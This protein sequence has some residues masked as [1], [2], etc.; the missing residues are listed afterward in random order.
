MG[1]KT[2]AVQFESLD[3][4]WSG[5]AFA[6]LRAK[7]RYVDLTTEKPTTALLEKWELR[8]YPIL[9]G[10]S[11]WILFDV[12]LVQERTGD[13]PLVLDE[14]RYGGVGFR[15]TGEWLPKGALTFLSSEGKDRESGNGA[16][17]R[18]CRMSGNVDGRPAAIVLYGHPS[19]FRAPQPVRINPDQPFFCWAPP[20]LGRFEIKP[21]EP[22]V[23]RYRFAVFGRVPEVPEIE[24]LWSDY[25]EPPKV[26][27]K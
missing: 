24:R 16:Q 10:A 17:A 8:V 18:W 19:N 7:N 5:A 11:G 9:G 13:T 21:G 27:L 6:G 26:S 15:G 14:Y 20:V 4:V 23:A 2:G 22:Y 12:D 3:E 25:A 1:D